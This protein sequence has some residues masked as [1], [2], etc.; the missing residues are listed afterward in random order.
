[1]FWIKNVFRYWKY[2]CVVHLGFLWHIVNVYDC[3]MCVTRLTTI[4]SRWFYAILVPGTT[5]QVLAD[6][7]M[8]NVLNIAIGNQSS[9]RLTHN[10]CVQWRIK[11][12]YRFIPVYPN[13]GWFQ[14][15]MYFSI[16]IGGLDESSIT[17]KKEKPY[18]WQRI[19]QVYIFLH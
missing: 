5:L 17:L 3:N 18:I 9:S 8:C 13:T 4:Y 10:T 15:I 7:Y 19:T 14:F 2:N 16:N 1:M 6:C 12:K 11:C